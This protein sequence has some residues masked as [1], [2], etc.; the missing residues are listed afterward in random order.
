MVPTLYRYSKHG[1]GH[2]RTGWSLREKWSGK[3]WNNSTKTL[4]KTLQS[5]ANNGTPVLVITFHPSLALRRVQTAPGKHRG[6]QVTRHGTRHTR[7]LSCWAVLRQG[8]RG[9][10]ARARR[11]LAASR[12]LREY[13]RSAA[14]VVVKSDF[15]CVF[16]FLLFFHQ[17]KIKR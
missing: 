13:P 14:I 3:G 4:V 15:R 9:I 5:V 1:A 17:T 6:Q 2:D 16:F 12:H 7:A 11:L 10:F 8:G